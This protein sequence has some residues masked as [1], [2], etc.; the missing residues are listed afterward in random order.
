[1]ANIN[2]T[3]LEVLAT[4]IQDETTQGENTA[5]RV[6]GMLNDIIDSKINNDK[7]STSDTL[8]TS[9]T[10]VPSQKAV[11]RYVDEA[12]PTALPPNGNAGGDLAGTYPNPT[13]ANG[14]VIEPKLANSSVTTNKIADAA[15]A[16]AKIQ[17]N[18]IVT[19][20]LLDGNV[21]SAKLANTAV[22]AG[23]Y[24]SA[25]ITVDA[26][27]RITA[28][29]NGSSGQAFSYTAN[30]SVTG[31]NSGTA[32]LLTTVYTN[33]EGGGGS[34]VKLPT[35]PT[36]GD[37][38]VVSNIDSSMDLRIVCGGT[39]FIQIAGTSSGT[40]SFAAGTDTN[41]VYT[42]RYV[43]SNLWILTITPSYISQEETYKVYSAL[44]SQSGTNAPTVT[45][46]QNTLGDTPIWTRLTTGVYIGTFT[47]SYLALKTYLIV[48]STTASYASS[49]AQIGF[50]GASSG[51]NTIGV[52][53]NANGT[54]VDGVLDNTSIE[55]RVY[56]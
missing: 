16:S 20:K 18:A 51:S 24:T 32:N 30:L 50:S 11:K 43:A 5:T 17:D 33:A 47:N 52:Y 31:T 40:A 1:M 9:D 7:I 10:L 34:Y 22:T 6:G 2:D 55:I 14:T 13:I 35:S 48:G 37:F 42:F 36:V 15:V 19:S 26:K 21:T 27:G 3:Q 41:Q 25:N 38:C 53:T 54:Q 8:G 45:V 46:L 49:N 44:L 28:A 39:Q 29:A 23:S 56:L 12:I 4:E